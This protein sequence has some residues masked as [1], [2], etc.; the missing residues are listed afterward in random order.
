MKHLARHLSLR[1]RQELKRL[2]FARQLR[3]GTFRSDESEFERL[4]EW[5]GTGDWV[6]DLGANVGH[7]TA[8]LSR[9]VGA[10]GR[11]LAF[12]PIRETFE[13]LSANVAR[14]PAQN[15]TLFNVA[16]S[17]TTR[18]ATMSIPHYDNQLENYYMAH[19]TD[20][21][22][23]CSVLCLAVDTLGL[24]EKIKLVKMDVEGHELAALKG[25]EHIIARDRPTL[26]VEGRSEKV[27]AVLAGYGYEATTDERSPNSVYR[28]NGR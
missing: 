1:L 17:D 24:A 7:Y 6:L 4:D 18:L 8:K 19:L 9:L 16:A 11:V 13:L 25:M 20:G 2:R 22:G 26:I 21:I 15:V 27:A 12:E 14:L 10:S 5:V 23:G 3:N 28:C